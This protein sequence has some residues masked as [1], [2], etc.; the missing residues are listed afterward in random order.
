MDRTC[1][2]HGEMVNYTTFYPENL[3]RKEHFG[4]LSVRRTITL[5]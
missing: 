2:I 1:S 3:K 4:N 5:K